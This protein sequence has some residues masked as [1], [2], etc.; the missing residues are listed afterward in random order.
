ALGARQLPEDRAQAEIDVAL[1]VELFGRQ[2]ERIERGEHAR[3]GVGVERQYPP[4]LDQRA[5]DR[6]GE[7]PLR[8]AE[9][10]RLAVAFV[11]RLVGCGQNDGHVAPPKDARSNLWCSVR[12]RFSCAPV[13]APAGSR[14]RCRAAAPDGRW[15][16]R[17]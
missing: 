15:F 3:L 4:L 9:F 5:C 17:W 16:P 11:A 8:Q 7:R 6:L 13:A 12:R 1:Y 10:E 2:G 14:A